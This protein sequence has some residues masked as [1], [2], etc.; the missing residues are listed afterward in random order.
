MC[1]RDR[2]GAEKLRIAG[3]NNLKKVEVNPVNGVC[4]VSDTSNHQVVR[5]SADGT[6]EA[7]ISGFSGPTL[8]LIHI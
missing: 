7:R 1:I 8:S 6:Q 2:Q 5:L 4:W 3:Y